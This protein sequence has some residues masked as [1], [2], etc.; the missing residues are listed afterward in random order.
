MG[1][2]S[3]RVMCGDWNNEGLLVTGS[4]DKLITIS[5][6]NSDNA[7]NSLAVKAEPRDLKWMTMKTE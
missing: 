5:N 4:E 3:K 6:H 1:K 7:G 2:H